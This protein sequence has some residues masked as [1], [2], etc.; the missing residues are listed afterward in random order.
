[1]VFGVLITYDIENGIL[2]PF[3]IDFHELCDLMDDKYHRERLTLPTVP[4]V[5]GKL[6]TG[7][8]I[9]RLISNVQDQLTW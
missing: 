2:T 7:G 8:S 9:K 6:Q 5:G 1:M 4:V 3:N